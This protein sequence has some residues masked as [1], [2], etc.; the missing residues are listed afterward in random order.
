[1][2]QVIRQIMLI[3]SLLVCF[4]SLP[5]YGKILF[6]AD[7]EKDGTGKEPAD[8]ELVNC[9]VNRADSKIEV[10]DDPDGQ[11]G[12]VAQIYMAALYVPKVA[13]RDNWT[14]WYWEWDWRWEGG[15][16]G[17]AYRIEGASNWFHFSPRSDKTNIGA[18]MY[19]G[20]WN[21]IILI[22]FPLNTNT[23][24]S[25]QQQIKGDEHVVKIKERKDNTPFGEIK[26]ALEFKDGT[27]K[28]GAVSI[29][30]TDAGFAWVDNF[31]VYENPKDMLAVN[32]YG[33][34]PITWG[35]VKRSY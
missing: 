14:D 24:Y 26:P 7:F 11:S 2:I 3:I 30:G 10:V 18:W 29:L 12:K 20:S 21:Q 35:M 15:N 19:N 1:M 16:P 17:T 34:S 22:P 9:P 13:G 33:K 28:K 4:T 27:F 8:F 6:S 32:G 31:N 25:F 23:W 5:V